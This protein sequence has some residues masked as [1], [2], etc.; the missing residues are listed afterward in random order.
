MVTT[1]PSPPSPPNPQC[2]KC[3]RSVA[4]RYQDITCDLCHKFFHMKCSLR[5]VDYTNLVNLNV[6][7]ICDACRCDTFPFH[8]VEA[9]LEFKQLLIDDPYKGL[10][11]DANKKCFD[12]NK[13]IKR[14]FPATFCSGCSNYF[15]IKCSYTTKSDFPLASDWQC[16]RCTLGCLP[17]AS[18]NKNALLLSLQ[19]IDSDS[20]FDNIPSFSIKSLLDKLPGQ[21]FST[22]EFMSDS[23]TSKYYTSGEFVSTNF[24]KNKFSIF[25]LNIASL[26]K[27]ID[28]LRCFLHNLRHKFKVLCITETRLHD[29]VPLINVD[30]EGYTFLHTPTTSQCGGTGIYI[31]NELEFSFLDEFSFC[32]PN[33]SESTFVEIKNKN[34]KNL[35]IGSIYRH[36]S[37]VSEFLEIF[38]RPALQKIAHSNKTCIFAGDFNVDLTQ[39]GINN[40]ADSFYNDISSFSFRP[41]ILQPTRVTSR[42]LTLIDN[43]FINDIACSSTGGNLTSSIS[44]HFSQFCHLDILQSIRQSAKSKYSRDWKNFNKQRFAYELSKYNWNDVTSPEVDTNTSTKNFFDNINNLLDQMAPLKRLT[45][46]EKGLIERPWITSGILASMH[47]R[48]MLYSDFLREKDSVIKQSKYDLYKTKRNM[49]TLLIRV[50]KKDHYTKYFTENNTNLK[51]TWEGIRGLINVSKKSNSNINKLIVQNK[52]LTDPVV[53]ASAMNDFFVNIGKSVDQKIPDSSKS[54]SNYLGECNNFCI[55]LNPCTDIE[56]N[57]LISTL[58]WSKASG[59]F[60]IPSNII[61]SFKDVFIAP[62]AAIVN[63]SIREGSFPDLLK[64]ATVHP[65]YKKNDKTMCAN[66][67]PISL[68][69]NISK[70]LERAMYNRIELFL[71]EFNIIYHNQFG[72]RKQHST[73]HALTAI[74]EE[75]RTNL[76]NKTFSAAVFIDLEKAFYTVNH[77]I[78]LSKLDHYGINSNAN[79][80][81]RSY[82]S[83]RNQNVSLNGATSD[84][85]PITCGVPQGSILGP[86]LFLLYIND[87]NLALSNCSVFHF[88]DDTNLLF[89]NKNPD[90]LHKNINAELKILFDWLCANRLSLNASKT[91][92]IIFRPPRYNLNKRVTLKLN[93]VTIFESP[94]IKYLGIILDS[95]LS[96]K[97]HVNELCKKLGRTLGMVYKVR[98]LCIPSVLRS[99]YFSLFNSHLTYGLSVWGQCIAE[100]LEK[101]KLIQKKIVRA[102]S[103]A[104][105]D[106]P[107]KPL[108]K[109]LKILS[110]DDLY[111]MQIASLMWDYDHGSLPQTLNK[112]FTRR[113]AV[114]TRNLRNALDGRL[115]TANRFNTAYGKKSFSQIGSQFLNN[116]KDSG[117]Y[118]YTDSKFVFMKKFKTSIFETY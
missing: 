65:I 4:L 71:N 23:I 25:H 59:P 110:I 66:Y 63:K 60:S 42:S 18:V 27:H 114:H 54:F 50:S 31:S 118:I 79:N 16:Q 82:L 48:D 26:Q 28:E 109:E 62:L 68:L 69:S 30:I 85:K 87:L 116:L 77:D 91:E 94:K 76:D 111:K 40:H 21:K 8:N 43:I 12:C 56:M 55:T 44:D 45:K 95:R 108:M 117:L 113:S 2:G 41:L 49:V 13:R 75:I 106:A 37:A 78:L 33:I 112:L 19:G 98:N 74:I 35:I 67:R 11:L 22:D 61:K 58:N 10:V 57:K 73:Q 92:F 96:W 70:I 101:L 107:T 1:P 9:A 115:Y 34:K 17:F 14:S 38:L 5:L 93:G 39:Y 104:N 84:N 3:S 90:I 46:K 103:F 47:S 83:N 100:Y 81:I 99:L 102:I 29:S 105:F 6:G 24:S 20:S 97:H 15:H 86:L 53:M 72:F 88:A 64:F 7:W 51:K 89:S 32:H 36:H 80:W 52:E